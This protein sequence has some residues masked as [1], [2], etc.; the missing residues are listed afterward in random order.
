MFTTD[1]ITICKTVKISAPFP[2]Q[3]YQ[4]MVIVNGK[5]LNVA[6]SAG[7]QQGDY[8]YSAVVTLLHEDAAVYT[9]APSW[10]SVEVE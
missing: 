10:A 3:A 7:R 4:R 8:L 1:N 9:S 2:L 6:A 5:A